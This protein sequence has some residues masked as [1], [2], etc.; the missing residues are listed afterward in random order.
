MR[1]ISIALE[2]I[3][4]M[5]G[6]GLVVL[7]VLCLMAAGLGMLGILADVSREENVEMGMKALQVGVFSGLSSGPPLLILFITRRLRRQKLVETR[8]EG[9]PTTAGRP[10]PPA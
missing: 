6:F 10:D 5:A 2:I 4:A 7:A 3:L 8:D 1:G 9:K